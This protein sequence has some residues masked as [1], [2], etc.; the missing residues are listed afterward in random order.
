MRRTLYALLIAGVLVPTAPAR[1]EQSADENQAIVVLESDAP[2]ARKE[3]AC[4]KLKIIGTA[5]AIPALTRLLADEH[6]AQ[7]ATDVLE[8]MTCPEAGQALRKALVTTSGKTR[9]GVALALAQRRDREAVPHLA[10]LLKIDDQLVACTAAM[11]LGRIGGAKA[12][13]A[14]RRALCDIS[15]PVRDAIV[16][17]LLASAESALSARDHQAARAIYEQLWESEK[18]DHVRVAAYRGLLLAHDNTGAVALIGKGLRGPDK[19]AQVASVE[20]IPRI[21]VRDSAATGAFSLYLE[22]VKPDVQVALLDALAQRGDSTAVPKIAAM[23]TSPDPLVRLTALSALGELGDAKQVPLLIEFMAKGADDE[24]AM[25]KR[26]LIRLRRGDVWGKV[27]SLMESVSPDVQGHL[28]AVLANRGEVQAVPALLE[29]AGSKTE[30]I[31]IASTSALRKLADG[32]HAKELLGLILNAPFETA[33][34][35]ACNTFVVVGIQKGDRQAFA[36]LALSAMKDAS[37][38]AK[39]ELLVAIARL[40]GANVLNALLAATKHDNPTVRGGAIRSLADYGPPNALDPLMKLARDADDADHR[41]TAMRGV[42]RILATMRGRSEAERLKLCREAMALS[43]RPELKR[44][45]LTELGTIAHPDA[46]EVTER[47]CKDPAVRK[48]AEGAS[49]HIASRLFHTHREQAEPVLRRLAKEAANEEAKKQAQ[50]FVAAL[51]QY[52]DFVVP[53]L[54][55][56]PYRVEGKEAQALFDVPFPPEKDDASGVT[57][58][59]QPPPLD[60]LSFWKVNLGPVAGGN[61][62]VVYAK[63]R[64]YAPVARDVVLDIGSDDGVKVW[65]NGQLIHANNAV[66]GMA[67]PT[68]HAEARLRLGWN[69]VLVK[70]T[71]HTAGCELCMRIKGIDGSRI[72]DMRVDPR[73][74]R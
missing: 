48:A 44:L 56:G 45:G 15:G 71:Q 17:G 1:A 8:T 37:V 14:L 67:G 73:G 12:V 54:V 4:R 25:A 29:M 53:W 52:A 28:T 6:L 23:T 69:D 39:C 57:W 35:E 10:R 42:W 24:K 38:P 59:K 5:R 58:R 66:R 43:E 22:D 3:D 9:A 13:D 34:K 32:S 55:A 18:A 41:A 61:H 21:A 40:G 64:V 36:E 19:A 49:A 2:A 31:S 47:A 70:V 33:R 11:A 30:I 63:T 62:S 27:L 50:A 51:N 72:E 60:A 16:D 65:L 74:G 26:S 7:W 46:L 20:M 68:D